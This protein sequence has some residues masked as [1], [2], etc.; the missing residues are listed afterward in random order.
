MNQAQQNTSQPNRKQ[1]RATRSSRG[2]TQHPQRYCVCSTQYTKALSGRY[3]SA[4]GNG[5]KQKCCSVKYA[6]D[7]TSFQSQ[8]HSCSMAWFSSIYTQKR[9]GRYKWNLISVP[10]LNSWLLLKST[11]SNTTEIY[12]FVPKKSPTLGWNILRN[13][14]LLFLFSQESIKKKKSLT[15]ILCG[16]WLLLNY[17]LCLRLSYRILELEKI[18]DIIHYSGVRTINQRTP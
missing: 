10:K 3:K 16:C 18:F 13:Y 9:Y 6:Y 8:I 14:W 15:W 1:I 7:V 12:S 2:I 5:T 11:I 4:E 17:C